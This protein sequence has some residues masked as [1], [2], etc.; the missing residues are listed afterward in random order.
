VLPIASSA[1]NANSRIDF[2]AS[3]QVLA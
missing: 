3:L 1:L 2:I